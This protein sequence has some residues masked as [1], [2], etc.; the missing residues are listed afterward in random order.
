MPNSPRGGNGAIA[1]S[2]RDRRHRI[3]DERIDMGHVSETW[4]MPRVDTER[5]RDTHMSM[6]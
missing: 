3:A 5:R 4:Q 2:R 6:Q 1:D